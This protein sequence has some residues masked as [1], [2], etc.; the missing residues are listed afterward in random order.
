MGDKDWWFRNSH[1][2]LAQ[3]YLLRIIILWRSVLQGWKSGVQPIQ[4]TSLAHCDKT[5]SAD[6][7]FSI[8]LELQGPESI[9][10]NIKTSMV[11]TRC[12]PIAVYLHNNLGDSANPGVQYKL[13]ICPSKAGPTLT[14]HCNTSGSKMETWFQRGGPIARFGEVS[15]QT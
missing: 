1:W 8:P 2:S 14:Y 10:E 6:Q 15:C 13:T 5:E 9:Y 7:Q 11:M 3:L 12:L 4:L